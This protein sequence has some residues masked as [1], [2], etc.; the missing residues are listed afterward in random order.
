MADAAVPMQRSRTFPVT[1][2]AA[3]DAV[4]VLPLEQLFDRRWG[5]LPPIRGTAGQQGA[6][7]TVGQ[8]RTIHLADGGTMCEELTRVQRPETFAYTITDVTGPMR[9]LAAWVEGRWDFAAAGTGVRVTW[10]WTVHPRTA[11]TAALL[12]LFARAWQ[13]YARQALDRL[14]DVLVP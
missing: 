3:F 7:G 11:A 9:A 10:A 12:P 4:L 6:W 2:E 1:V 8:S 13:G 14:E 5:P